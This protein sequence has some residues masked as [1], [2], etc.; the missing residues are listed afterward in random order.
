MGKTSKITKAKQVARQVQAPTEKGKHKIR[1][2]L[3]F[4]RPKTRKTVSVRH[5][6]R[7]IKSELARKAPG[8]GKIDYHTVIVQPVSSDKNIQKMEK[9]NTMTFLVAE[10][11]TKG[12]IKEAFSKLYNVK[13]R[14]VNTLNTAHGK[15]KAY[16]RLQNDKDALNIASKIGIL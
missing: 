12:Q 9:E 15:K 5:S 3:R 10:H 11:S 7:S 8:A 1:T 2:K 4:Y 6:L 16:I 14:K 13:V